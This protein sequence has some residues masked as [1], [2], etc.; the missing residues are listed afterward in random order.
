MVAGLAIAGVSWMIGGRRIVIATAPP[1]VARFQLTLP[2]D[3]Q[4]S[5]AA[6][7]SL[8][9]SP[10]GRTLVLSAQQGTGANQ[11]WLRALDSTNV[12]PLVGTEGGFLPFWSPDNAHVAFF[13]NGKLKRIDL[14]TSAVTS[15]CDAPAP[16]GG[17]WNAEGTIVFSPLLEGPLFRVSAGGG[18]PSQITTLDATESNHMWPQFLPDGRHYLF[19]VIGL[20]N[21]G[22]YAGTLDSPA[23]TPVIRQDNFDATAIQYSA[24]GHLVYVRNHQLVARPFDVG[25]MTVTGDEVTLADRFGIGGPG[26]PQFSISLNGVLAFRPTSDPGTYQPAWFSR[27]GVQQGTLG[28]PGPHRSMELSKDG[29]TLAYDQ[30]TEK[31]SS[32]WLLDLER[33]TTA[34]FTSESYSVNPVWFPDGDRLAYVSVR[35]TPP[36]P[37]VKTM[38]G[39]ETRLARVPRAVSLGSVTADGATILGE[40]FSPGTNDDLW[41]FATAPNAAPTVFL[42]TPFNESTPR[43]SPNGQ[44]VAFTSDE[45]GANEIYVTTFPKAGRRYRVSSD[46]GA[47]ARWNADGKEILYRSRLRMM[48]AAFSA[49]ADGVPTIGTPRVLF[50]L[51][52]GTADSWI[53]ADNGQKFLFDLRATSRQPSPMTVVVN[54][55]AMAGA[56]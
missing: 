47:S 11:L 29:R 54:W 37:F 53:V 36:N 50:T 49:S 18:T 8:S 32:I 7:G 51:P 12:T 45:S 27:T 6:A 40:L 52:E 24:S 3:M 2:A 30:F 21:R 42:Q 10:D 25:R 35:D 16:G 4:L 28:A 22:I 9:A 55:P 56:K 43:L 14:R 23:R 26:R 44:W 17:T 33:G 31:E 15:I 13:A 19:Q 48:A 5:G 20:N 39:V 38:A 46:L 41:L 1:A 34:R